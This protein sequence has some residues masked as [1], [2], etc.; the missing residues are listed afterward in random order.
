MSSSISREVFSGFEMAATLDI[1]H[2][3]FLGVIHELQAWKWLSF[4]LITEEIHLDRNRNN[5]SYMQ[6]YVLFSAC[7]SRC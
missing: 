3:P 2:H 7:G 6:A 1:L 4:L 5:P